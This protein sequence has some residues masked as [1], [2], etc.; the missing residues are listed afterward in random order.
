MRGAMSSSS[1]PAA[2]FRVRGGTTPR[3]EAPRQPPKTSLTAP[4]AALRVVSGNRPTTSTPRSLL[5]IARANPKAL[6]AVVGKLKCLMRL[7]G[8]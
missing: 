1:A 2:R 6:L 3:T 5:T 8:A 7:S 4:L